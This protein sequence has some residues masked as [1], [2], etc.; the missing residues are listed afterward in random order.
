M[1]WNND[2][3]SYF[4]NATI[5]RWQNVIVVAIGVVIVNN[6]QPLPFE[7]RRNKVWIGFSR[8]YGGKVTT[9]LYHMQISPECSY[10]FRIVC[11]Q[12]GAIA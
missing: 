6:A 10:S 7:Y 5:A 3:N 9:L 4:T 12:W 2:L 1:E 11:R 8:R